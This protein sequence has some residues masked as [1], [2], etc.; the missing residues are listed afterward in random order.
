MKQS[1]E[2]VILHDYLGHIVMLSFLNIK[3]VLFIIYLGSLSEKL[4]VWSS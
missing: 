2:L 3:N 1:E 4:I